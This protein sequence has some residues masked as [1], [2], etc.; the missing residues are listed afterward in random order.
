MLRYL[1]G[2]LAAFLLFGLAFLATSVVASQSGRSRLVS[3]HS[4]ID[5]WIGFGGQH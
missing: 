1:K 3:W 2:L 5:I 4:L